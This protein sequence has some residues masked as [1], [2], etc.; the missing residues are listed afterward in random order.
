MLLELASALELVVV[1]TCFRK[2]VSQLVTYESGEARTVVD[3]VL[4]RR[5]ERAMVR[6]AKVIPGEPEF[7]QH[8]LVVCVLEVQE[9]VKQS[10]Q[11]FVSRFKVWRL[12]DEGVRRRF[13]EQVE[14]S[15]A[16]RKDC[17]VEGVWNG[18][19]SCLLGVAEDVCGRTKGRSR[20]RETWWWNDEVAEAVDEKRRLYR[21]WRKRQGS[22]K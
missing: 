9:C 16:R 19:K 10:K 2:R 21:L 5:K 1:N 22:Q 12:R 18:L 8:R 4:V 20:R 3:Y 7:L 13:G 15:A 6:D 11:V 14:A 17:D